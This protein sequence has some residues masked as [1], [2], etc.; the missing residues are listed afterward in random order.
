[1]GIDSIVDADSVAGTDLE[2]AAREVADSVE[3]GSR[4]AVGSRAVQGIE[5]AIQK[6]LRSSVQASLAEGVSSVAL[7]V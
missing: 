7:S 1:M 6:A 2:S 4:D 5:A 3:A